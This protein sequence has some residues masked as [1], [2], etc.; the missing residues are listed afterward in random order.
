MRQ[1]ECIVE[2]QYKIDIT[3]MKLRAHC[4]CGVLVENLSVFPLPIQ[5]PKHQ[6][7]QN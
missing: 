3:F 2:E 5:K 7:I 1:S 6:N 4:I